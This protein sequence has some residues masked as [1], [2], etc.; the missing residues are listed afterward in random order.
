V[1][2]ESVGDHIRVTVIATGF[3]RRPRDQERAEPAYVTEAPEPAVQ[4][5]EETPLRPAARDTSFEVPPDVLEVPSFLR[6][7]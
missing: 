7:D 2:D 6:D 1:I 4:P 5:E 3:D